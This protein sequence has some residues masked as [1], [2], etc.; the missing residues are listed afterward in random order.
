MV[1]LTVPL[2]MEQ[3]FRILV[4]S[5]DTFMLSSFSGK[6][7]AGVG[8]VGQYVFFLQILFNV[9]CIGASIVLSQYLGAKKSDTELNYISQASSVMITIISLFLTAV[10]IFGLGPLLSCYDIEE[11]VRRSAYEYFLIYGGFCSVFTAFSLLQSAI[12]RA[13]GH[14]KEAMIVTI[15][16]NLINVGGNAVALY[17]PLFAGYEVQGVAWASG[18]SMI[19]SVIIL[20]I[21]IVRKKDVQFSFKGIKSVPKRVYQM[22]LSIGVPTAGENLSYNLANIAQTAMF[23]T[24]GTYVMSAHVYAQT[25]IRFAYALSI[26][27]G[28]ATQ[29]KTGYYVGEKKSDEAY[30][31][32]YKYWL[33]AT[34]SSVTLVGVCNIFKGPIISLF[35]DPGLTADT[36]SSLMLVSFFIEFGRCMNLIFVGGLKGSGDI[37]FPVVYGMFSMWA[38]IVGF[39]WFLG[40]FLGLGIIGFW[41]A[42]GTEETTRGIAMVLRWRSKRWMKHAIV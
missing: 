17:T 41:L 40:K 19:V 6:A 12:L 37:K 11:E 4:S 24:L 34:I 29:I 8:L 23:S 36:T 13:Y 28:S 20:Q 32:L 30:H 7:V 42:V 26:A 10:V 1:K 16:A 15:I 9:V 21:M 18:V 35:T 14:T 25:I 3:F 22:I 38:I 33:Y 5:V 39:G 31:R 27:I 2:A